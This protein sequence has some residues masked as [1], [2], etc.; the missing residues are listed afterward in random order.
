MLTP[1][2]TAA[3]GFLIMPT[4]YHPAR[5][6]VY[7]D[8]AMT[9]PTRP[10]RPLAAPHC[11]AA[12]A[13]LAAATVAACERKAD[14]PTA[15]V[16]LERQRESLMKRMDEIAAEHAEEQAEA[17][18]ASPAATPDPDGTPPAEPPATPPDQAPP[19]PENGP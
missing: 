2:T 11:L 15:E 13:A 3:A 18:A 19:T 5:P 17:P 4:G 8:R 10:R 1:R 9:R 6:V 16:E 12:A 7:P 14:P